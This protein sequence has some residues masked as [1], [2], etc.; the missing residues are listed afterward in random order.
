MSKY[1][2]LTQEELLKFVKKQ[3]EELA[4]KRYGIVWDREKE[5]E[6]VVLDC[7]KNIPVLEKVSEKEIRTDETDDNI[8]I[9]GDN[10]HALTCLN[11]TH[12]GK[13]DVIYIDPPYNTGKA[14]EWIY[15]DKYIDENDGYRHSN[16]LNMMEKRL[17][18]AKNL[19]SEKG[20]IF[21][22]IGNDEI[23]QLKMLMDKIFGEKK[24]NNIIHWKKNQKPQNASKT[25]SES[26]EFLLV[27]FPNKSI[28]LVRPMKGTKIDERGSYKPCPLFKF[29]NRSRRIQTIPKETIVES[30]KWQKGK[31][32]GVRNKI[33][34]IDILDKPVIENGILKN[35]VRLEGQWCKT[36]TNG[37]FQKIVED[38]R[39]FINSNGFPNEKA[40]R[41]ENSKNVQTNLWLDAGYNEL[42]K[43]TLDEILSI[44][45]LFP[46][47]KPKEY[48]KEILKTINNEN[49]I[50]LDF[51]AGSGTTGHATLELNGE[52]DGNRKFIICT[53]NEL[54]G[55]GRE[56][57]EK[58]KD[59]NKEI[60]GVCQKVTYPRIKKVI[61]GYKFTGKD[62][63]LLFE[64]KLT[65]S[66]LKKLDETLEEINKIIEE[67]KN[68]Y[69]K[70]KKEFKDN[71]IKIFGLK[72]IDGFKEGLKGNLQYFKTDFIS[73]DRIDIVGDVQR[74]QL[75][76]KAGEMIAIKENTF[77][78]VETN[79]WYQIF[80]NKDKSK[81][82]AIYF[83][84]DTDEL[85]EFIKKI[86]KIQTTLYI[87]FYG[88]I[89]KKI[90]KNLGNNIVIDEIPKPIFEIY[91][92]INLTLKNK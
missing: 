18:L 35:N 66:Q 30:P 29:D 23:A 84:E 2:K 13:I 9:E 45:N 40:Y 78:K 76:Y 10:Y 8:L 65:F 17:L 1:D 21:V 87:F 89:D 72:Y 80:E 47:P 31:I 74:R 56:L 59:K 39:L 62:K 20:V 14:K 19:L 34:Y 71:T 92:K 44:D 43:H 51:F 85:K 79:D 3:D 48:I 28:K 41:D 60:F 12:K 70:I 4:K 32:F 11:Y 73:I 81:K 52:D 67:N 24:D 63:K 7:E 26:A 88:I 25:I 75:I 33:A 86:D 5:S 91:K 57:A 37:E 16:W 77:E 27:Y 82:T 53:N 22:S 15:N 58:N 42:G 69:D 50:I 6:Q 49:A 36:E 90:I 46:Y 61:K 64:K 55:V 83:R 54:N 38:R 68:N